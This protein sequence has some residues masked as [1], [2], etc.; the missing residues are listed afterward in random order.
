MEGEETLRVST[1]LDETIRNSN[2]TRKCY[3]LTKKDDIYHDG[4]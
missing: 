2:P 3:G 1:D 4:D